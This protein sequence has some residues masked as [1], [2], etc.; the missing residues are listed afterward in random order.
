METNCIEE[1]IAAV[2]GGAMVVV[3]D[4]QDRENEGDII[5]AAQCATPESIAFMVRWTSGVLCVAL[6]AKRLETLQV[7]LMVPHNTDS[8]NT[9][10]TITVDYRQGTTTGISASD[11]AR[12]IRALVDPG[13]QPGDFNRP[14]HVFPL[15]AADGGVLHRPGHTEAAV[16]LVRLAG[17]RAGGV[18]AE[19]VN[20]DGE[21]ARLP[22]LVMFA[23]RFGLPLVTI[24]DLIDYRK[25]N[26]GT[27]ED[28]SDDMDSIGVA[29]FLEAAVVHF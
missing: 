14:G 2:A 13:A 17:M 5:M 26:E 24:Q 4:A 9:A 8:M 27:F 3:V 29:T 20:E 10:F 12:T 6:P 16:D 25:R 19:I 1:A 18:L 28:V 22:E 23:Q 15:R 7:P 11:R 21:M